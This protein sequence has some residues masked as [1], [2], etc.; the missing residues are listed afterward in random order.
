VDQFVDWG[1]NVETFYE[2]GKFYHVSLADPF[3]SELRKTLV[4]TARELNITVH[5]KGTYMRISGPQFSTRAASRMYRNFADLIGMTGVP[6]AILSR[7]AEICHAIISAITD[8][9]VYKEKPVSMEE[10]KNTMAA[11]VD[12]VRRLIEAAIPR[13]PKER[14]CG[15]GNAL[16]GAEA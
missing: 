14:M 11:N 3:C 16:E 5:E 8:Y 10:I 6:E 13:I 4:D 2:G 9:D 12:N 15:C 1:K 7:E